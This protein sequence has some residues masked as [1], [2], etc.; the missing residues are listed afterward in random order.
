MTLLADVLLITLAA[1]GAVCGAGGLIATLAYFA[2][3][4]LRP[5]RRVRDGDE[6]D[7]IWT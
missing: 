6:Q 5:T 7:E 2:I 3:R 1:V 4:G